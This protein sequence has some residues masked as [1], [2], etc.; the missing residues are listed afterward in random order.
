MAGKI[1]IHEICRTCGKIAALQETD[2]TVYVNAHSCPNAPPGPPDYPRSFYPGQ[3]IF[4]PISSLLTDDELNELVQWG[5]GSVIIS[6]HL[7]RAL[8]QR[9]VATIKTLQYKNKQLSSDF[10]EMAKDCARLQKELF[11]I[12]HKAY[13]VLGLDT[14]PKEK[15]ATDTHAVCTSDKWRC[16]CDMRNYPYQKHCINCGKQVELLDTEK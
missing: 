10:S 1:T 13:D 4:V 9:I 6:L 3:V 15:V 16:T 8:V 11:D 2:G 7:S 12:G 14:I 5:D